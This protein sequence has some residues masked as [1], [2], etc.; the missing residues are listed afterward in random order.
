M[1]GVPRERRAIS[2]APSGAI[3]MP[4]TRAPQNVVQRLAP[5]ARRLDEH[6][7]VLARRFLAREVDER[8]GA[9]RGVL[10][11]HALLGGD[12]A[13]GRRGQAVSGVSRYEGE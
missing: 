4:K 6:A 8:Q 2:L 13:S 3:P 12:E 7:E 1:R 5:R 10:V 9:D 11:V